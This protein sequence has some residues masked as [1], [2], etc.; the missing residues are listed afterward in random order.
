M[1]KPTCSTCCWWDKIEG[2]DSGVCHGVP[3]IVSE[4]TPPRIS[5]FPK[6]NVVGL[7]E[8]LQ[9]LELNTNLGLVDRTQEITYNFP[10]HTFPVTKSTDR[11]PNH[12]KEGGW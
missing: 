7:K 3:P 11:C 10:A 9:D 12:K 5:F 6:E 8:K 2:G 4:P 1:S